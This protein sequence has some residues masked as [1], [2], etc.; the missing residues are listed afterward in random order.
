MK[1]KEIRQTNFVIKQKINQELYVHEKEQIKMV[2]SLM[3]NSK[4]KTLTNFIKVKNYSKF[5][6]GVISIEN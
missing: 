6:P 3:K 4:E 2:K 1:V 5:M